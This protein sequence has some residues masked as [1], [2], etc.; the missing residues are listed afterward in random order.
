MRSRYALFAALLLTAACTSPES[1]VGTTTATTQPSTT[2]T[3][4]DST[5]TSAP[6]Q[7]TQPGKEF[8]VYFF[9]DGYPVEPGPYLVP[10]ERSGGGGVEEALVA[11][12]GGVT[13]A[14]SDMG[15]STVIPPGTRV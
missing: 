14:E 12:M 7:P 3:R 13:A 8:G 2:S 4:V 9:F 6:P 11:L 10:V 15:L 5:T 1:G